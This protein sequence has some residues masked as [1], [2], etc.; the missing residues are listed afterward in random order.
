V[1]ASAGIAV[2]RAEAERARARLMASAHELQERLSPKVLARDTWE[3]A[4][5]KG[6]DLVEDAV[7][8][9]KARPLATTG[10]IA[11]ITMFL[12]RGPLMDLAGQLVDGISARKAK[13]TKK[14]TP[15]RAPRKKQDHT[16]TVQ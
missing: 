6:A 15:R 2:A 8:A 12:A 5:S 16:E 9:V 4:K 7:D 10:V 11:A 14:P 13:K 3:G 1:S